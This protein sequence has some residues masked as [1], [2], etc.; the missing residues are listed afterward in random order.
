LNLFR[1]I[2]KEMR[3]HGTQ[4]LIVVLNK[5]KQALQWL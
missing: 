2:G 3:C 5:F 1:I 4:F